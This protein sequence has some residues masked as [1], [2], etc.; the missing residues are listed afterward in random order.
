MKSWRSVQRHSIIRRERGTKILEQLESGGSESALLA[1]ESRH[2]ANDVVFDIW[3]SPKA[4]LDNCIN[5]YDNYSTSGETGSDH[6]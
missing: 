2:S 3:S 1:A 4:A 6:S 5:H